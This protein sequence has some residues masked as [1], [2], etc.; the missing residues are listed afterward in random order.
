M[1]GRGLWVSGPARNKITA[2][3]A[4]A[5]KIAADHKGG[6]IADHKGG[7][8]AADQGQPGQLRA[9]SA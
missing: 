9:G 5:T 3:S 7:G 1:W 2:M 6:G 8:I 4:P